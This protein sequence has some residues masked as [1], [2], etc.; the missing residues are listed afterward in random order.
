MRKR[1]I[2]G[3]HRERE[4]KG[5]EISRRKKIKYKKVVVEESKYEHKTSLRRQNASIRYNEMLK[6]SI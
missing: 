5:V 4:R 6:M 1:C 2:R 3:L